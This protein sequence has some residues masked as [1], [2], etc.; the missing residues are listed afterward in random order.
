M[1][2]ITHFLVG[3]VITL[4]VWRIFSEKWAEKREWANKTAFSIN[5]HPVHMVSLIRA[6]LTIIL[7]FFSH[8]IVDG[9]AI[10]TYHPYANFDILFYKIWTPTMLIA[11][12]LVFMVAVKKDVRYLYGLTFALAF[13]LWDYYTLPLINMLTGIQDLGF[14]WCHQFEWAFIHVFLSWAP[15]YYLEPLAAIIEIIIISILLILWYFM[16]RK[17]PLPENPEIQPKL[18]LYLLI[19][20]FFGIWIAW[21]SFI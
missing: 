21:T 11:G 2:G 5:S 4:M 6:S 17:W 12:I 13:D 9:F 7:A 8:A 15:V 1:N 14:L 19:C 18:I 16:Q 3:I 20:G 10:F